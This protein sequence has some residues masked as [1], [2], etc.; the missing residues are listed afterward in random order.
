VFGF[1]VNSVGHPTDSGFLAGQNFDLSCRVAVSPGLYQNLDRV[2]AVWR[3]QDGRAV[4]S[5]DSH[6][7][8]SE[9]TMIAET[10]PAAVFQSNLTFAPAMV[11]DE[12]EY[13]CVAT[14]HLRSGEQVV[15]NHT[16]TL[17]FD[18][19]SG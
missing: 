10:P 11:G 16:R 15:T 18:S 8:A 5:P 3:R 9:T 13:V 2:E 12:G 1:D 7:T 4:G 14:C 17:L 6:V 19:E